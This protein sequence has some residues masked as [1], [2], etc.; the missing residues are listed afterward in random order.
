METQNR[1]FAFLWGR[2]IVLNAILDRKCEV[3]PVGKGK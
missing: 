3:P 1:K 2:T